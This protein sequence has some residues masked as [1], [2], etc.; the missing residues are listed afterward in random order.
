MAQHNQCEYDM[1]RE[2]NEK[3]FSEDWSFHRNPEILKALESVDRQRCS[4]AQPIERKK[5][6]F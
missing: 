4:Y 6:I 5:C 1:G 2:G 3:Y